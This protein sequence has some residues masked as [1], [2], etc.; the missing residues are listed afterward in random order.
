MPDATV[1]LRLT[2][3]LPSLTSGVANDRFPNALVDDV[4]MSLYPVCV[5]Y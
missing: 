1:P 2:I 5:K 3:S 4:L